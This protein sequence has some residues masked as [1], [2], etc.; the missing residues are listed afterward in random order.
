MTLSNVDLEIIAKKY[1][2]P[3]DTVVS[4]DL[5]STLPFKENIIIN[6]QDLYNDDNSTN[7]GSHWIAL[8]YNNKYNTFIYFDS[9]GMRMPTDVLNY[10]Y[11][12]KSRGIYK[13]RTRLIYNTTQIQR[14]TTTTCGWYCLAFLQYL[15]LH[16]CYSPEFALNRF[17][18]EFDAHNSDKTDLM[19]GNRNLKRL[20]S[21]MN[22]SN[23]NI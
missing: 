10:V 17:I 11:R 18:D 23:K 22:T 14:I 9:Y 5:L 8:S 16:P 20:L 13:S 1:D 3:L 6:L 12:C 15:D 19:M 2:I 4:K 7:G 21:E